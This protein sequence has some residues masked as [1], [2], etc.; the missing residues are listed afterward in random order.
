MLGGLRVCQGE[1][2]ITRF[3]TQKAAALLD[4]LAYYLDRE[5]PRDV[6]VDLLW[7]LSA[8]DAARG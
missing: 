3:R 8:S 5:H 2:V 7:P 6:L 1:R 4:Y